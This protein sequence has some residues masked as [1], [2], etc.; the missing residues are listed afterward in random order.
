MTISAT[1]HTVQPGQPAPF[2]ELP[3]V[4]GSGSVSLGDYQGRTSLFLALFIGLWCPFC[5]RAIAQLALSEPALKETGV[6]TLCVVATSPENAGL[7][8]KFRPNSLRVAADPTL[9]THQAYG[10]PKPVPT[11]ELM[12]EFERV[13]IN[14][15]GIFA[16]PLPVTEAAAEAARLDGYQETAVDRTDVEHQWPQL[17]GQ[18]LIDKD[19][20]V[21]W[22]NIECADEGLAGIGKFPSTEA[23]LR[24]A[25][26]TLA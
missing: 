6:E 1:L 8:F 7:Y 14:P 3:K 2:F 13:R 20:V 9:S 4:D 23:I 17:K 18:F 16:Q 15:D 19:C 11:P 25:R 10:V 21:R 5:R 12:S 22:T 24:A 26:T